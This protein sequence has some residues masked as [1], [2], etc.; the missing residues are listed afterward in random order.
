MPDLITRTRTYSEVMVQCQVIKLIIRK[1]WMRLNYKALIAFSA[2]LI[3]LVT[4]SITSYA[5]E[6][7]EVQYST[8]NMDSGLQNWYSD[9]FT[10]ASY[11]SKSGEPVLAF[12]ACASKVNIALMLAS[13]A[14]STH[15]NTTS[16]SSFERLTN[17]SS[18]ETEVVSQTSGLEL[19]YVVLRKDQVRSAP[20]E[21]C[22]LI[23]QE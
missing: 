4:G 9:Y 11:I 12:S 2:V 21:I 15:A 20:P 18:Y 10:G 22:V 14:L 6:T 13:A 5:T 23:T 7:A 19:N 17:D 16:I 1:K 8:D 3:A